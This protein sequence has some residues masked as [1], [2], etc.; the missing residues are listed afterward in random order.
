MNLLLF[1]YLG[2]VLIIIGVIIL[3][4]SS[5]NP[6]PVA[7]QNETNSTKFSDNQDCGKITN[8]T[9]LEDIRNCFRT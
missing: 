4:F 5:W 3:A 8:T 6:E 1:V 2:I 7:G 9:T